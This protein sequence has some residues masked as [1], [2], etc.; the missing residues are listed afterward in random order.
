MT[1][2]INGQQ[3]YDWDYLQNW[4]DQNSPAY[5]DFVL[6]T[7]GVNASWSPKN[8]RWEGNFLRP[9]PQMTPCP[10]PGPT[11]VTIYQHAGL[12]GNCSILGVGEYPHSDA[13][14]PVG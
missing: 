9:Q 7:A 12:Q 6:N 11:E 1:F 4:S 5:T 2:K 14:A 8:G 10:A 3:Y 13:F